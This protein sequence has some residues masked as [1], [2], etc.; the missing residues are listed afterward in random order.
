[1]TVPVSG[2]G[3][4]YVSNFCISDLENFA[5][6]S[7]QCI[8]VINKLVDSTV[9]LWITSTAV[10]RVVAECTSLGLLVDC[11]HLTPFLR[12]VLDL[13]Y[14]LFRHYY[15]AVG[16]ILASRG[17]S[18]IA[19]LLVIRNLKRAECASMRKRSSVFKLTD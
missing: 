6:A 11:N 4:G 2:R 13:S 19:E 17:S 18:M 8:G 15:L 10:E 9:S 12:F 3:L 5:T 16:K 1:M 14:K 7:R